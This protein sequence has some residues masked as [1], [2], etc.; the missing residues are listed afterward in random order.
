MSGC[1]E[2]RGVL[3]WSQLTWVIRHLFQCGG[4]LGAEVPHVMVM[5]FH[6]CAN[7]SHIHMHTHGHTCTNTNMHMNTHMNTYLSTHAYT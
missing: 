3:V 5:W 6:F 4:K 2:T 7:L 1:L